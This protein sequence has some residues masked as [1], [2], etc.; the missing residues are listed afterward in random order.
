MPR[1]IK[2]CTLTFNGEARQ[3]EAKFFGKRELAHER[4]AHNL[5]NCLTHASSDL[6][7]ASRFA[8]TLV[9]ALMAIFCAG[10]V[11]DMVSSVASVAC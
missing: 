2:F 9:A 7:A 10:F 3:L 4:D 5:A 1:C 6:T 11:A 8:V